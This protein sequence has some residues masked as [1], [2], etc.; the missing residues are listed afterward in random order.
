MKHG[1]ALLCAVAMLVSS[2]AFGAEGDEKK[3]KVRT[4]PVKGKVSS[5]T[6]EGN[7]IKIT[8]T[9]A[10]EQKT[11][12]MSAN[13]LLVVREIKGEQTIISIRASRANKKDKAAAGDE[14]KKRG[15][16][17]DKDPDAAN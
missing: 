10:G 12:T 9:V 6:V 3:K 15:K 16:K 8:V 7:K 17:K 2:A 5:V 13:V 14:K 11:Y 1:I 4:P